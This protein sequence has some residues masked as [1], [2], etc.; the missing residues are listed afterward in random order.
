MRQKIGMEPCP[1][2]HPACKDWHLT[3][4]GKFVQSSG[5]TKE[6]AQTIVAALEGD[7]AELARVVI[8]A[9]VLMG[10]LAPGLKHISIPDYQLFN[11]WPGRAQKALEASCMTP[12]RRALRILEQAWA[13]RA[14]GEGSQK[15][16]ILLALRLIVRVQQRDEQSIR[17][18][19]GAGF[20]RR[21]PKKN[22]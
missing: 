19:V 21:R 10:H 9:A 2:G 5:F 4:I 15:A 18:P 7:T 14:L 6:E 20:K 16:D 12:E 22:R 11:E 3:G 1:C 8:E 17:H 13:N